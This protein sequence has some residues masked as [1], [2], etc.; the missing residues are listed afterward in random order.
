MQITALVDIDTFDAY[1]VV[2]MHKIGTLRML[3]DA[4]ALTVSTHAWTYLFIAARRKVIGDV[5]EHSIRWNN[6]V[7]DAYT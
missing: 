2:T 5:V 6:L 3:N 1:Y 4:S 7:C